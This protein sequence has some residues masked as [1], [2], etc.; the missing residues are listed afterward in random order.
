M[1][2]E[3]RA[4][5][6]DRELAAHGS[7]ERA[8]REAAYL[9]SELTHYGVPVP[10]IRRLVRDAG[11]TSTAP[12]D[13]L[14]AAV[15]SLWSRTVHECRFAGVELL[16]QR[17]DLLG[18]NDMALLER[19]LRGSGTWAL[20]D[21]LAIRVVGPLAEAHPPVAV[22]VDRWVTDDDPWLRRAAVLTSLLPLRRGDGD[23]ARFARHA[24]ALLDDREAIVRKALGWVLRDTAKARPDLV[25]DWLAPRASRASA[26]TIR[27]AVK[28][29]PEPHRR[30]VLAA[31]R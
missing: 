4:A 21:D 3:G 18:P 7:P 25:R 17:V 13:E 29:L 24:D 23:F 5:D 14:V 16:R 20:L 6:L 22:T 1:D 30:D 31:R 11:W 8:G 28:H 27:E 12:H 10:V 19:L 2:A 15:G 26:V 9:R